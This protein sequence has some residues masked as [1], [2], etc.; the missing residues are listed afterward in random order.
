MMK[1]WILTSFLTFWIMFTRRKL[2]NVI[3]SGYKII[4][5]L[6]NW[7]RV[8]LTLSNRN[9]Y[10][11]LKSLKIYRIISI[12]Y[13]LPLNKMWSYTITIMVCLNFDILFWFS[14][15]FLYFLWFDF[16][17]CFLK[18]WKDTWLQSHEISYDMRS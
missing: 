9:M 2:G 8:L 1:K 3:A 13:I 5:L 7:S 18:Q 11:K 14:F 6:E 17:F 10:L 15:C 4:V 16:Q 12:S